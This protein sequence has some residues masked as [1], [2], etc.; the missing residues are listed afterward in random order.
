MIRKKE[1]RKFASTRVIGFAATK[2]EENVAH[3]ICVNKVYAVKKYREISLL[4]Q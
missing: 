2:H 1:G 4:L 3:L